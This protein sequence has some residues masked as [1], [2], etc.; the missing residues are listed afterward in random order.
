MSKYNSALYKIYEEIANLIGKVKWSRLKALLRG[1]KHGFN[2]TEEDHL[3]I[4]E[5]LAGGYYLILTNRKSH[6]STYVI[7]LLCYIKTR[8]WPNYTHILMNV[9]LVNDPNNFE[10]FKL[11]EATRKGVHYSKFENVF[12]CDSVCLIAPRN[13]TKE[14]WDS[15]MIGLTLQLGKSY[16][17]LF[18][19]FDESRVSCVEVVLESLKY[20][21]DYDTQ[22]PNLKNSI[23][24]INNL[25][26]Q[27]FRDCEDFEVIFEVRK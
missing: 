10:Q 6:L 24:K 20:G 19:L 14:T 23:V 22:F 21:M 7:G 4:Q 11:I 1:S 25:T 5:L 26:P 2:L 3:R 16:D 17:N 8:K 15:V 18:D 12:D 27:M 13:M 9:D